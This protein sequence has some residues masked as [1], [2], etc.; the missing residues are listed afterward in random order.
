MRLLELGSRGKLSLTTDLIKDIPPYAILS[1]TWGADDEEVTFNDLQSGSGKSK[2]GYA[3]IQFCEEQARKDGLQY[4]SKWT[5]T[6]HS[7]VH[8]GE[9]TYRTW[10]HL[11]AENGGPI[12][13]A[14]KRELTLADP[15]TEL[16][17]CNPA[18][19]AQESRE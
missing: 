1:H 8:P 14:L 7:N 5:H 6:A 4:F 13:L 10:M 18:I 15:F 16:W 2:A 17:L 9:I 3:K 19:V 11:P 12:F